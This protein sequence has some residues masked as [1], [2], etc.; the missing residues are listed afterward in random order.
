MPDVP[1]HVRAT[2]PVHIGPSVTAW[3]QPANTRRDLPRSVGGQRFAAMDEFLLSSEMQDVVN[4]AAGDMQT[5]AED[6]ARAEGLV[7]TGEYVSSFQHEPG[8]VVEVNDGEFANPRVSAEVANTS[9]HAAAVEYGNSR[10]GRG[11]R[12]LGKIA[13]RYS[14]PKGGA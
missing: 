14:S 2:P 11:Y 7:R 5:D 12:I 6:L 1:A 9:D 4:E 10:A 3:Y 8:P 13:A